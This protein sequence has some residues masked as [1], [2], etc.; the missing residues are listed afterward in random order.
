MVTVT[1][2]GASTVIIHL[3]VAVPLDTVI[4]ASPSAMPATIPLEDTVSTSSSLVVPNIFELSDAVAVS[5]RYGLT[6]NKFCSYS[7]SSATYII[8]R[9]ATVTRCC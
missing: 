7:H 4:V 8:L 5:L 6:Y 3:A 2:S 9:F 1:T